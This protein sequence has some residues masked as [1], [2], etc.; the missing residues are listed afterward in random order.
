MPA[1]SYP[2]GSR[3]E[4]KLEANPKVGKNRSAFKEAVDLGLLNWLLF[5]ILYG[6]SND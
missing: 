6:N 2:N 4:V 3:P 1:K 5:A